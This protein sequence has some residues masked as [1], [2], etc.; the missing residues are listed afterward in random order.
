[1]KSECGEHFTSKVEQMFNDIQN[2]KDLMI[3]YKAQL[4]KSD[5]E[6][7]FKILEQKMWPVDISLQMKAMDEENKQLI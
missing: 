2:S 3:Q 6:I 4:S 5:C 1:M 7:E